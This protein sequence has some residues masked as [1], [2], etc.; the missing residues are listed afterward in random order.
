MLDK[1][2]GK[3]A[4][5]PSAGPHKSRECLPLVV[6][7][8]N[9]L[10]Y[11]LTRKE[12]QSIM[13]Q[14]LIKVDGKTRVD[15][16]YPTGFMD[17]V[18]ID[19]TNEN[20][21][22]MYDVKGRFKA[23]KIVAD[24][25]RYKLCKVKRQETGSRGVPY[26]VTHDGR[27][28]RYPDPV[29]KVSDTVKIDIATNKVIDVIKFEVGNLVMVTG[30]RNTGRVG[31]VIN[32]EKH[33]GRYDIIHVKDAAGHSF[34]TRVS[35]IFAIGWEKKALVSLPTGQGVKLSVDEERERR[36]KRAA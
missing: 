16:N 6:L 22:I 13:M 21:R 28:I 36:L 18:T 12:V 20:F 32:R 24:E 9:R 3:W 15:M 27:T 7:L 4:P 17:V 5:K 33:V 29:V 23:H 35:N 8:R 10:K 19:K 11:A 14:R 25:A 31:I 1:M 30:G 26:I 34:S 2:T